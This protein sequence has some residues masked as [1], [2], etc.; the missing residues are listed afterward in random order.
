VKFGLKRRYFHFIAIPVS[1]PM[2]DVNLE[3]MLAI[4]K[5]NFGVQMGYSDH[6]GIEVP[7][8]LGLHWGYH[9]D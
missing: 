9:N 7:I 1:T 2:K 6:I 3:A 4:Q 5:K 8:A